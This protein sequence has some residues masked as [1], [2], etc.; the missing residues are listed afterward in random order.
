VGALT[1]DDL[2]AFHQQRFRPAG[3][4]IVFV[5]A[6]TLDEAVAAARQHFG[7]WTGDAPAAVPI[8]A[9]QPAPGGRIYLVD[10]PDAAQAV[11]SQFLPAPKRTTPDYYALSLADAV[12]GGGGFATRLNLNLREEKGYSYGVFSSMD[13]HREA[14]LW[15]AQGGVQT[16]KTKESLAE[17]DKELK[18]L[19]GAR[20]ITAEEFE[21]SRVRRVRGYAQQFEAYGR[22]A[23][24]VA[25]LW[26]IGL[27]MSE[28]QREAD[29][30]G[31]TTLESALA[32][33]RTWVKPASASIVVVGD[34][35]KIEAGLR[36]LGLGGVVVLDAEGKP[37]R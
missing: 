25:D 35:A 22:V 15:Y 6:V 11:I 5:G 4:A 28:L 12:W 19:A 3:T 1:R 33:T 27:P 17:F 23:G 21:S 20:P 31:R 2:V 14:G 10:R 16:D 13:L 8:P 29:E 18:D 30:T 32:A 37:A 24:Q 26:A 7:S 9:P 36:E 34:R